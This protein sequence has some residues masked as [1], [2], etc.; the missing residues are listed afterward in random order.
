MITAHSGSSKAETNPVLWGILMELTGKTSDEMDNNNLLQK[1]MINRVRSSIQAFN[2]YLSVSIVII[3]IHI[4]KG[5][6]QTERTLPT[7]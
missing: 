5:S 6:A 1:A 4:Y 3:R 2:T 7:A